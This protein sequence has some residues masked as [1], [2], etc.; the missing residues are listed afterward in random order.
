MA[1]WRSFYADM[2]SFMTRNCAR[3]RVNR[4]VLRITEPQFA[5]SQQGPW[6]PI[7][8]S[9]LYTHLLAGLDSSV[10]LFVYPWVMDAHNQVAWSAF[11]P[12][13]SSVME[14]VFEFAKQWNDFLARAGMGARFKGAVLDFEEFYMDR[15][16]GVLRDVQ[17]MASLKSRYGFRA[18]LT[19]GYQ[20]FTQMSQWDSVID[21]F[22][23]QFYDYYY[24]PYVNA[25]PNSPFLLYK[26][27]PE[28]LA[29]FTVSTVLEGKSEDPTKYNDKVLVMWSLQT[30]SNTCRYPL[31]NGTC[32]IN[33]EFG[34]GWTPE[35]FNT[36]LKEFRRA[37]PNLGK[38]PQGLFQF[39]FTPQSWFLH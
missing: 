12:S 6:W 25:T 19:L 30:M 36:Y 31:G 29:D 13:G 11:G 4:I 15:N 38:K 24:Q 27:D 1:S 35:A 28:T 33:D 2:A 10:E 26:N 3:L 32:G 22:Y 39:S 18:G 9:P 21:D 8:E 17:G 14:G 16:P 34:A 5:S 7:A 37:S 20:P 23:L